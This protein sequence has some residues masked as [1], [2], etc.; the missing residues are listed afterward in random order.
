MTQ[1]DRNLALGLG[2]V[3]IVVGYS[4]E[5]TREITI[6]VSGLIA[7]GLILRYWPEISSQF[8]ALAGGAKL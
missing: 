3:L 7:V 8:H 1:A 5:P 4:Y 6:V 2:V